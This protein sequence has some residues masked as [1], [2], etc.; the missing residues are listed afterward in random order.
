MNSP[1]YV[2]KLVLAERKPTLALGPGRLSYAA[3]V[4]W[5]EGAIDVPLEEWL[6]EERSSARY[7]YEKDWL[8]VGCG[9]VGDWCTRSIALIDS[10]IKE[11]T[12]LVLVELVL[13]YCC[14]SGCLV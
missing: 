11:R 12:I 3:E 8:L 14:A 7:R 10:W 9:F 2:K 5:H 1:F 13:L 6:K 4:D